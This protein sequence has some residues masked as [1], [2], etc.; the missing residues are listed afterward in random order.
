M[1]QIGQQAEVA[2]RRAF[3]RGGLRGVLLGV[4]T[5]GAALLGRRTWRATVAG[6]QVCRSAGVCRGCNR[7]VACG[8]PQALYAQRARNPAGIP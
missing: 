7:L 2:D 8:L 1:K 6:D 5:G 4:V 3:L